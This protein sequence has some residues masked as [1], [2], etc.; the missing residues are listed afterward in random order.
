ME[1]ARA[2]GHRGGQDPDRGAGRGGGGGRP[3][4]LLREDGRGQRLLRPRRWTTWATRPSTPA[5]SCD[6]TACSRSSA[7][8]N[9]PMALAIGPTSAAMMAGNTVVFKPASRVGDD[10]RSRSWRPTATRA[11][12]TASFNLVMGPGSTV[13]AELQENRG[14]RRHRVHRLVRGGL[15]HLP[16]LLHAL[17]AAVHRG[18]GRQEPGDRACAAR[19]SRRPPRASCA[20]RS[21]SAARS[22]PPTAASTWSGRSTTS[23]SACWWRR[24][25]SSPWATRCE[26]AAFLGPV[27]DEAAVAPSPAGGRRG[28]PRRHACSPAASA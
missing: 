5:R 26:R 25:R 16:Q 13:G 1:Y 21:A 23:W 12:R 27:I 7:P 3:H 8:F 14:H 6:R 15:R 9:F 20:P 17:P 18:D 10:A 2:D 24:P 11:S 28:P 19:T 22:A 4:P